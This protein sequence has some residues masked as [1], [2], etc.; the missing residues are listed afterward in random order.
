MLVGPG[1]L[2]DPS[3]LA[4]VFCSPRM[5]AVTTLDQLLSGDAKKKLE[6]ENKL[7]VT[8]DIAEWNYGNYEGKTSSEIKAQR[9]ERGLPKWNIW[10][11]G[12]EK[13]E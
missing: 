9:A 8:E 3:K 2:I 4:H 7:S 12:C 5:R 6:E 11:D 13:G 1:K 10:V